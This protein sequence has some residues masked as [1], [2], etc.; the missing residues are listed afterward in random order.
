MKDDLEGRKGREGDR[1][2]GEREGRR[3]RVKE[4][5]KEIKP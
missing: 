2:E 3:E 5:R 4:G 1:T